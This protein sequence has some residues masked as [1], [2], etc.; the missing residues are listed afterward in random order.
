LSIS[1]KKLAFSRVIFLFSY[2]PVFFGLTGASAQ[3]VL[4]I[5]ITLI[6]GS[7]LIIEYGYGYGYSYVLGPHDPHK[8]GV[9]TSQDK[10]NQ[11]PNS[12]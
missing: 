8:K 2:A 10:N 1:R 3:V 11:G 4:V 9:K 12:N 6:L 5:V 7:G